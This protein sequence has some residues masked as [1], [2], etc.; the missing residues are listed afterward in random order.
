MSDETYGESSSEEN[1]SEPSDVVIEKIDETLAPEVLS[2]QP[3][4]KPN[5]TV[6]TVTGIALIVLSLISCGL[7]IAGFVSYAVWL[8]SYVG[9]SGA[10]SDASNVFSA[11]VLNP[12]ISI[13]F[14][15]V[16]VICGVTM[17]GNA[18]LLRKNNVKSKSFTLVGIADFVVAFAT[19][20]SVVGSMLSLRYLTMITGNLSVSNLSQATLVIS[21]SHMVIMT[22]AGVLYISSGVIERKITK[23]KTLLVKAG[24]FLIISS[25]IMP[26][27]SLVVQVAMAYIFLGMAS[28]SLMAVAAQISGYCVSILGALMFLIARS[29]RACALMKANKSFDNLME[30]SEHNN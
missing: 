27:L 10:S 5:G 15:I 21:I 29:I 20:M 6:L 30:S 26:L 18:S 16:F 23:T 12:I 3:V 2:Y 13:L 25:I 24:I 7:S 28:S 4:K 14:I 22:V 9:V 1:L 17:L 8:V 11:G 19:F